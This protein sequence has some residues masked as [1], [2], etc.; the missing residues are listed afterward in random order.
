MSSRK[1]TAKRPAAAATRIRIERPE[2]PPAEYLRQVVREELI[3]ARTPDSFHEPFS[4][5]KAARDAGSAI[6][7]ATPVSPVPLTDSPKIE[8][9]IQ[10]L[11]ALGKR[12]EQ[13]H[14]GL[15]SYND[16]RLGAD[17]PEA[18]NAASQP[19]RI[20]QIGAVLDLL[21]Q[22]HRRATVIESELRRLSTL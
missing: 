17:A 3:N 11:E 1:S 6:E 10:G 15:A 8:Q 20:G 5:E 4:F 7:R 22:A 21:E 19:Q 9:V 13:M 2:R 14:I 16:S 18:G 12:L